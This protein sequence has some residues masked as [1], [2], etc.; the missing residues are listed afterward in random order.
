MKP[1]SRAGPGASPGRRREM[2]GIE[3]RELMS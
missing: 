2:Y 3:K 1:N